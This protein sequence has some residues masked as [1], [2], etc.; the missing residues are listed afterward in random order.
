MEYVED[1]K[2]LTGAQSVQQW[3]GLWGP[4]CGVSQEY[5]GLW[6]GL[7]QG[8]PPEELDNGEGNCSPGK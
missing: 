5:L 3:F 1:S 2:D 6:L 7:V 4:A 8:V